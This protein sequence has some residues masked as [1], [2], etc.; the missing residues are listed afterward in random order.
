MNPQ[1]EYFVNN[2]IQIEEEN[3]QLI[4]ALRVDIPA[5]G[6]RAKREF[7]LQML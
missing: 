6:G 2:H 3:Q 4:P 5:V 1:E 7:I